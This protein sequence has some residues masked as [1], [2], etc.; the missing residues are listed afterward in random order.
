MIKDRPGFDLLSEER[1]KAA[2]KTDLLGNRVYAFW[3]VGSTNEFAYRRALQGDLEGV[4]VIAEQQ[5]KG[6]G[7]KSRHWDSPFYKGLWFSLI[8]RPDIEASKAGLLPYLAGVSVAE[9]VENLLK[10]TP[11]L[12]WP[13]DLLFQG[14]KFCGILSEVEFQNGKVK[15]I[16]LGIGINVNQKPDEFPEQ[17][18]HQATSLRQ[19]YNSRI[20][21]AE[22]LAEVLYCLEQNYKS[23]ATYGLNE[24]VSKWKKRCPQFGKE[25]VIIQDDV[26]VQG[27]FVDIDD[28][29]CLILQTESG[30]IKKI[31]AGDIRF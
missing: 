12:K 18:Q 30:A 6:K 3:S 29:G 31:V 17:Y 7:R 15:F 19:N 9:A 11:D 25:I 13:N 2:L 24:I 14:K 8:L 1:I 28:N 21:R 16:I 27:Q 23:I 26:Q 20:D 4:L 5:T 22:L 10:L